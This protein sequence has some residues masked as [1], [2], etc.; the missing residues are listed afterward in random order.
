MLTHLSRWAPLTGVAAVLLGVAGAVIQVLANPPG[1][2]ASGAQV[3]AFYEAHRAGE[4]VASI[5]LTFAFIFLVFFAGSLRAHLRDAPGVEALSALLLAG[6][7]IEL[8]GQSIGG[9]LNY[10]LADVPSHLDPA[11]AQALNVLA[12][13]LVLTNAAGLFLF[14]MSAGLAILRGVRMPKW[15]GWVAIAIAI[16]VVTPAEA[17]AFVALAVWIVVVSLLTFARGST[18]AADRPAS[19]A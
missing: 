1:S 10:A 15:L 4:Q 9:G 13:D 16:V 19:P 3:I 5:L 18:R 11:A 2:D 14:G 7:A 6:A 8:V 12:N 17:L